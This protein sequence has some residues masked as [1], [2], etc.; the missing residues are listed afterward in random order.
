M[1]EMAAYHKHKAKYT[2]R[3]APHPATR[4]SS[5]RALTQWQCPCC[6]RARH[7]GAGQW[8]LRLARRTFVWRSRH[9][10]RVLPSCDLAPLPVDTP[11]TCTD[12]SLLT[13]QVVPTH[14]CAHTC[15]YVCECSGALFQ[16]KP[17]QAKPSQAKPS[18]AEPSRAEPSRAEPSRVESSRAESSRVESSRVGR[19]R[20]MPMVWYYQGWCF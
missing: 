17:S 7:V 4:R 3:H 5:R 8:K 20:R 12:A 1:H 18:Q 19:L 9:V 10:A 11:L 14:A 2:I 15:V 13:C 16:L 6:R